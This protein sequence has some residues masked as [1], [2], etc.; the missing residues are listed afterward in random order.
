MHHDDKQFF[1]THVHVSLHVVEW[2][3]Y[4]LGSIKRLGLHSPLRNSSSILPSHGVV[5]ICFVSLLISYI[6]CNC[7]H[8]VVGK[9]I[10][11]NHFSS[12]RRPDHETPWSCD[13]TFPID[14]PDPSYFTMK[15]NL[16]AIIYFSVYILCY[17]AICSVKIFFVYIFLK[18]RHNYMRTK[19]VVH[20]KI[21]TMHGII[22]YINVF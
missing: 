6:L 10:K 20:V 16:N 17:T 1:P 14:F 13:S 11:A 15:S 4:V 3:S 18:K 2:V 21:N 5:K 9:P 8:G 19:I 12:F 22:I 7:F